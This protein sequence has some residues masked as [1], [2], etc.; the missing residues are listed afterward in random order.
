MKKRLT[1]VVLCFVFI[2]TGVPAGSKSA[3]AA[4]KVE[5]TAAAKAE[6]TQFGMPVMAIKTVSGAAISSGEAY[7]SAV[8]TTI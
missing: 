6:Y 2:L 5:T 3:F 1:A 4:E 8:L 7:L